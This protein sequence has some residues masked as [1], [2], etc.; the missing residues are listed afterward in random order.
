MKRPF[1]ERLF[2]VLWCLWGLWVATVFYFAGL[3][4]GR[5]GVLENVLIL[6]AVP[7][8]LLGLLQ[9]LVLGFFNPLKLFEPKA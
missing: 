2:I 8:F 4:I 7:M 9:Y 6:F 5:P 3:Q 1:L